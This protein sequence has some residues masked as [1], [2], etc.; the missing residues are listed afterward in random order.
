MS[1]ELIEF[2]AEKNVVTSGEIVNEVSRILGM[3]Q[4][5]KY[6][7]K[8]FIYPLLRKGYVERVRQKLYHVTVPGQQNSVAD[9][10]LIASKIREAYFI[11][12]HAALEFYG[13]AYSFRNQVHVCVR[14][15][16]RFDEF[17]YQNT[18]YTPYHTKE[19]ETGIVLHSHRG[20]EISVC[21]KERLFLECVKHPRLVGGW[22]EVLKS[23]QGLGGIDFEALVNYSIMGGNQS[24]IRK[25]GFVLELLRDESIYYQHLEGATLDALHKRVNDNTRYLE[26]GKNGP[27][28]R[29]W[30]LYVPMNFSEYLRGI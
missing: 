1:G 17:Q 8:K 26:K 16:N 19:V 12:F 18:R 5:N 14:P 25:V 27:L 3:K 30:R 7:Y 15:S 21:S 13:T 22:E 10:F 24:V 9:R 20:D 2:I 4:K 29:K 23:L 6:V 11:G 28:N